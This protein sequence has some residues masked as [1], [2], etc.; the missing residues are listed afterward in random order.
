[1]K[2]HRNGVLLSANDDD[3]TEIVFA[4]QLYWEK[5][6]IKRDWRQPNSL[7]DCEF[8][9]ISIYCW[10]HLLNC[11]FASTSSQNFI[12]N[13]NSTFQSQGGCG[14][15]LLAELKEGK[16]NIDQWQPLNCSFYL[17]SIVSFLKSFQFNFVETK[18]NRNDKLESKRHCRGLA[19]RQPFTSSPETCLKTQTKI[20]KI[21]IEYT[22]EYTL[23]FFLFRSI[24]TAERSI[25]QIGVTGVGPNSVVAISVGAASWFVQRWIYYVGGNKWWIQI[26]WS[27]RGRTTMGRTESQTEYELR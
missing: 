2:I 13:V 23:L 7:D 24:S 17:F 11:A 19:S 6:K 5:K 26:E 3:E 20:K 16:K 10:T 14:K 8:V 21:L 18:L 27:G 22:F 1:M 12:P 4:L 25:A 9:K 15:N